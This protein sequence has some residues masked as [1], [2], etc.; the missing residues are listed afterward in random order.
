[1]NANKKKAA[2]RE[3]DGFQHHTS[4]HP[5]KCSANYNHGEL[6][7][8]SF[9]NVNYPRRL[10]ELYC[11][12]KSVS[13]SGLARGFQSDDVLEAATVWGLCNRRGMDALDAWAAILDA[14][15]AALV[16]AHA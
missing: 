1:M 14:H 8:Q 16:E 13:H 5:S 11:A 15:R 7:R 10:G 4:I 9:T 2:P 3:R 6:Q 12:V